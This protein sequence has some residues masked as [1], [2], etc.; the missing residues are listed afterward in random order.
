M[1]LEVKNI[2]NSEMK[3]ESWIIHWGGP[4]EKKSQE[5]SVKDIT[6]TNKKN[7]TSI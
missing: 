7:K 6:K 4:Y 3:N 5:N 2:Y 1:R